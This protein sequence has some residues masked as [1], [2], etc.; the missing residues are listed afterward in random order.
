MMLL[1][2]LQDSAGEK[3]VLD[4]GDQQG[5]ADIQLFSY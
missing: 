3:I 1:F 5:I 4:I 2:H